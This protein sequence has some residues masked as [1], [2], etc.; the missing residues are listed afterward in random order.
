MKKIF[1]L[2]VSASAAFLA[3]CST[4]NI[5]L[6]AVSDMPTGEHDPGRV[7]WHDLLTSDMEGSQRFYG[8]LFGWEFEELPLSLGVGQSSRYLLIRQEGQLI[9]GMVDVSRVDTN[10][11]SSQWVVLI[12]VT[13][14]DAATDAARQAGGQVLTPPTDLN[15]RGRIAVVTDSFGALFAMLETRDGD[16]ADREPGYGQFM[17]DEVWVPDIA[18]ASEFYKQLAPYALVTEQ[19]SGTN[20]KGLAVDGK[21]RVG[22]LQNPL[23]DDG[24][25]PTW[26]SYIRVADMTVLD[27]VAALGGEVLLDAQPRAIGGEVAIIRG[28]SGAGVALQTWGE[29]QEQLQ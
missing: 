25:E 22:V 8:G 10:A 1:S 16:P 23:Q 29:N 26:V 21:P 19:E 7:I 18:A 11:N 27:E 28:P 14:V 2:G 3:A 15:E 5:E 6:P 17:W 4:V 13:D 24:L 9:G 20:Y 12:S